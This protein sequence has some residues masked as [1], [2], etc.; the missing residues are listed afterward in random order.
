MDL[1]DLFDSIS[2][3]TIEEYVTEG[4]DEDLH[5]DFKTVS[6]RRGLGKDDRRNFAKAVSGFANSDGG[7]VIWG[8]D[9][10][11][12]AEGIDCA[13]AAPGIPELAAFVA[14]LNEYTGSVTSPSVIGVEHRRST[15]APGFAIT[16]VPASDSGPHMAKL[17]EDRYYQRVGSSF[18][19][20]EHFSIADMFGRR[21][22]PRLVLDYKI[23]DPAQVGD[24]L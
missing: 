7:L 14:K 12:N 11:S 20:M 19:K 4:R 23:H 9:A 5:L 13:R 15:D 6:S 22:Q 21:P 2:G 3:A 17:T 16:I 18:V 10:R 8:V 1:R 24:Q